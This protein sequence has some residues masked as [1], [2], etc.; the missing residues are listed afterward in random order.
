MV[1]RNTQCNQLFTQNDFLC[2][3]PLQLRPT[4]MRQGEY[5]FF[6]RSTTG[7]VPTTK[8]RDLTLDHPQP[9]QFEQISRCALVVV[10]VEVACAASDENVHDYTRYLP[11][12][13]VRIVRLSLYIKKKQPIH[14][15]IPH[16]AANIIRT[17]SILRRP[18]TASH[19]TCARDTQ[20]SLLSKRPGNVV[21]VKLPSARRGPRKWHHTRVQQD[22]FLPTKTHISARLLQS[23]SH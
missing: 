23:L 9:G 10:Q 19:Q 7:G 22:I 4:D 14:P 6:C 20:Q 1:Q 11:P 16:Q 13:T 18:F 5:V 8:T 15:H 21:K 3:F 17:L 2:R 12:H